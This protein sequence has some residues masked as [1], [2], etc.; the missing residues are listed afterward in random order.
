MLG[1]FFFFFKAFHSVARLAFSLFVLC[2]RLLASDYGSQFKNVTALNT[3][4]DA[5]LGGI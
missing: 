1:S 3:F 2:A 5:L 4:V